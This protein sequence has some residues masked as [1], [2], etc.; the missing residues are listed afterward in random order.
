MASPR[1]TARRGKEPGS[2]A[3]LTP[4]AVP[5]GPPAVTLPGLAQRRSPEGEDLAA[6]GGLADVPRGVKNAAGNT[7][8]LPALSSIWI[9]YMPC[10]NEVVANAVPDWLSPA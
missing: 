6:E 7:M 8:E 4:R 2:R 3:V 5:P 10:I 1:H 9:W